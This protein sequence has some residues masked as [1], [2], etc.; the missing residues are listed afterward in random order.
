MS[1]EKKKKIISP[2]SKTK[3]EGGRPHQFDVGA[4]ELGHAE[5]FDGVGARDAAVPICSTVD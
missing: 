5:E 2:A 3:Q 4:R 1:H